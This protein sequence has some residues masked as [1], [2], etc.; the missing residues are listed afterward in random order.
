[1]SHCFLLTVS[2]IT[3][4]S[5]SRAKYGDISRLSRT[6]CATSKLR[7]QHLFVYC[8]LT[9]E[10]LP[11]HANAAFI[12]RFCP[13][14][15]ARRV[16]LTA[17]FPSLYPLIPHDHPPPRLFIF[18]QIYS[19]DDIRLMHLGSVLLSTRGDF[20]CRLKSTEH[21]YCITAHRSML[22]NTSPPGAPLEFTQVQVPGDPWP[23]RDSIHPDQR[24]LM[25]THTS[26]Q[27]ISAL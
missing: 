13:P 4:A 12:K 18:T 2:V 23:V 20:T 16:Y 9:A 11:S 25:G 6:M 27:Q 3:A 19:R 17:L 8:P 26:T 10:K 22:G 1:M 14:A 21:Y 5:L 24:P 15:A 7:C